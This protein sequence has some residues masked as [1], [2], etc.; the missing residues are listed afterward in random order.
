MTESKNEND[1]FDHDH[2]DQHFFAFCSADRKTTQERD[3]GHQKH[4]ASMEK[5]VGRIF[6]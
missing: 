6:G 3:A 4:G 2:F 1:H 5:N